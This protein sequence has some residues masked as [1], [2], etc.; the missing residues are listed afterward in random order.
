[1]DSFLRFFRP[2]EERGESGRHSHYAGML[3]QSDYNLPEGLVWNYFH[4]EV[5]VG[6]FNRYGS[7]FFQ[8]RSGAGSDCLC[9][10]ARPGNKLEHF[11]KIVAARGVFGL[12]AC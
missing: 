11:E 4:F 3:Q 8:M 5:L 7:Q 1:M 10:E 2:T 12:R 9:I 6:C